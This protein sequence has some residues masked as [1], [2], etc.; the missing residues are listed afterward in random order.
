MPDAILLL[1]PPEEQEESIAPL[2]VAAPSLPILPIATRDDLRAALQR[3]PHARLISVCSPVIVPADILERLDGPA[4]NLHP[5]P[6]EFPGLY[7][8]VFA[9]FEGAT[10]F[11]VT[12]HEMTPDVDSG[13]IVA[14]NSVDMPADIDRAGLEALS[15]H[16]ARHLLRG[17]AES[18][19]DLSRPLPRVPR[20]W[21]G[22]ARRQP[23][24]EA[25]CRLP[26]DLDAASFRHRLRAVGEG[27]DH[28]LRVSLFGRWFRLEPDHPDAPVVKGGRRIG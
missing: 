10:T 7:P 24:F 18:L 21:R 17:M 16:L 15:W 9:L 2:R 8:A 5:G 11:G 6:P 26:P 28:A 25:L 14:T 12:L 3:H 19:V 20:R 23:D 27:P 1:A 22:P 13:P 4:Y